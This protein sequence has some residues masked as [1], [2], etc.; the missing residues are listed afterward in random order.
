MSEEKSLSEGGRAFETRTLS[1]PESASETEAAA[2][3]AAI[4]SHLR[5]QEAQASE[6][7]PTWD[8]ER[9]AFAGRIEGTQDRTVRVPTGAPTDGWAAAGRTDRF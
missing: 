6:D 5:A 2:I 1:L 4:S 7:E 8:G 3:A 9:W